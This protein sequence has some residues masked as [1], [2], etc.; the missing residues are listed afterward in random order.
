MVLWGDP[1]DQFNMLNDKA[2]AKIQTRWDK[3]GARQTDVRR[4]YGRLAAVDWPPFLSRAIL[5]AK[6]NLQMSVEP[7]GHEIHI[8][9]WLR[10]D[11]DLS[12]INSFFERHFP[13]LRQNPL[14]QSET[15]SF[16]QRS[17]P[18]RLP[19]K[20]DTG[21]GGVYLVPDRLIH[22]LGIDAPFAMAQQLADA[23]S[24]PKVAIPQAEELQKFLLYRPYG[25]SGSC[26][27]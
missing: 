20:L 11:E 24:D 9:T 27:I 25:R 19:P 5:V 13:L 14:T 26:S 22:G 15:L 3:D 12:P 8:E 4:V 23:L 17:D 7:R 1:I 2:Q 6:G 21:L 16:V 10:A 18:K